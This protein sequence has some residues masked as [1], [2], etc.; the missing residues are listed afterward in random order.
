MTAQHRGRLRSSIWEFVMGRKGR[1]LFELLR[2]RGSSLVRPAAAP[3][4]RSTPPRGSRKSASASGGLLSKF[5][6][7]FAGPAAPTK[8]A[9]LAS[10]GGAGL[11][12]LGV[13]LVALLCL[14]GGFFFGRLTAPNAP[15]EE[16]R[17]GVPS[18]TPEWVP[19]S[20]LSKADEE[21][22]LSHFGFPLL[23]CSAR[24]RRRAA[25]AAT[26]F[27]DQGLTQT[28]IRAVTS[29]SP[30]A[31]QL[32]YLVVCYSSEADGARDLDR[33]RGLDL[34][35]RFDDP[36]REERLSSLRNAVSGLTQVYDLR[37]LIRTNQ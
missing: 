17:K 16:L 15:Q 19:T 3:A 32:W 11:D 18:K 26:W 12:G 22:I 10:R 4:A 25:D 31:E 9:P 27:R 35:T 24:D 14:A 23:Q 8:A 20:V 2:E 29:G 30:G 7:A 6:A 13:V 1:D 21:E 28:R 37:K 5:R 34:P 36:A 33:L